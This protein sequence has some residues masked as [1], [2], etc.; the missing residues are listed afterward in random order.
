MDVATDLYENDLMEYKTYD[1]IRNDYNYS[2]KKDKK[3]DDFD[4]SI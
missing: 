4:I 1:S 3:R 2:V